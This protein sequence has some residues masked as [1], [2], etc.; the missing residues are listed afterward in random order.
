[1]ADAKVATGVKLTVGD[2]WEKARDT[3]GEIGALLL[4][5]E[6]LDADATLAN[7]ATVADILAGPN[8]E[9]TFT[10]YARKI[11]PTVAVVRDNADNSITLTLAGDPPFFLLWVDSGGTVNNHVGRIVYYYDPNP[12]GSTDAQ[13]IHLISAPLDVQTD[14]STIMVT[15]D[16]NGIS[17]ADDA[18]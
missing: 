4:V 15:I 10:N 13:R 9:A 17:R 12:G 14:G 7:Y 6:G 11:L 16:D 5:A 2:W 1:V 8:D 3:S 18:F